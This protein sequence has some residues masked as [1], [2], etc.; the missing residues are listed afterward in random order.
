MRIAIV[1]YS[2]HAFPVQLSRSLADRGHQVLHSYFREFQS[3]H[4]KLEKAANDS[5]DLTIDPVSLGK[6]FPK[7]SFFRRRFLEIDVGKAF[8]AKIDAFAPDVVLV[9]N[10]PLDCVL[11]IGKK[12]RKAGRR[13]IFWQQ[14]I[15]SSAISR[16][17]GRKFGFAGRM[18][19]AYYR[20]MERR[21]LAMSNATI[22]ISQDFV[23][24]IRTELG[25]P[26]ANVHVIENWAPLDDI[27]LR[28][29]DN[30]WAVKHDLADK[31]VILYSGTIGLK[32]DPEQLL[33]L[34]ESLRQDTEARLVVIS[35]GP[36]AEWL[37][38]AGRNK[39]LDNVC[40]LPF[41]PYADFP[42]VL[43]SADLTIALLEKDAGTFSVPSKILS[44]LC[45]GRPI[46]LSAPPEN[47]AARIIT[48]CG[49]GDVVASGDR[50]AFVSAVRALADNS[51]LRSKAG[52]N[53]RIYAETT[54][55]IGL[56]TTR[57]EAIFQDT[58]ASQKNPNR[59]ISS[60]PAPAT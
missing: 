27:P 3:P 25:M 44:Y 36:F 50:A 11:Q 7:Y 47:L 16:I 32:H 51:A 4:G 12:T 33:D 48:S 29:K 6:P 8:A 23:E 57:F 39:G 9:G 1:D 10:C 52:H 53:A 38:D 37:A 28:P 30:A 20:Q 26:T 49:A 34:A 41:Q 59:S 19:G 45:A 54:F 42:D 43:G 24:A 40:F 2:G 5:S 35:E 46:V 55:N 17:L 13:L 58:L 18:I 60:A 56:I 31:K 22:V 14:D 15:Y 21:I